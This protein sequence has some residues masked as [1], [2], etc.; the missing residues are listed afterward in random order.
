MYHRRDSSAHPTVPLRALLKFQE[1]TLVD[2]AASPR[3]ILKRILSETHTLLSIF[4]LMAAPGC[5]FMAGAQQVPARGTVV[6]VTMI[7]AVDS[8]EG[9]DG[10][11]YRASVS[12]P[13]TASNGV[14]ILQNAAAVVTLTRVGTGWMAHLASLTIDG[15]AVAVTSTAATLTQSAQGRAANATAAVAG[16]LMGGFGKRT[17]AAP[18]IAAGASGAR[19]I[20]PAGSELRFV[21]ATDVLAGPLPGAPTPSTPVAATTPK[22]ANAATQPSRATQ[23]QIPEGKAYY[24]KLLTNGK[25][26]TFYFTNVFRS[27]ADANDTLYRAWGKYLVDK[28]HLYA[29]G[30]GYCLPI[31]EDPSKWDSSLAQIEQYARQHNQEVV[32]V[33]W[34]FTPDQAPPRTSGPPPIYA[35]CNTGNV[36]PNVTYFS[37]V[38]SVPEEDYWVPIATTFVQYLRVK[39]SYP[40]GTGLG[41]K[42][43][44]TGAGCPNTRSMG[45][46]EII[47]ERLEADMK[48][49]GKQVVETGWTYARTADTPP[50]Q[51]RNRP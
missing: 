41:E 2:Q 36:L 9:S 8:N 13:V 23:A 28:Y 32:R 38:S 39:Y 49:A 30:V 12:K 47:K 43:R 45:E 27:T 51:R 10:R 40:P 34:K 26:Q 6:T 37:A 16:S 25:P 50:P 33:D 1:G 14:A 21:L 7:D 42:W 29:N 35:F 3:T 18:A 44:G 48:R 19:V 46:T 20:L 4:I 11:Q 24:C 17:R 5:L 15:Q 31:G 22:P